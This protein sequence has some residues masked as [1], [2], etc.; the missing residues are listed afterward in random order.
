MLCVVYAVLVLCIRVY[1]RICVTLTYRAAPTVDHERVHKLPGTHI[2]FPDGQ[3]T[4]SIC[5]V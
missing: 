5:G 2:R 1:S 4:V 3:E